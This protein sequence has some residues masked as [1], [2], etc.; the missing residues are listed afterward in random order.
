MRTLRF[1]LQK[2]FRQIFRDRAIVA[3]ILALPIVQ[4]IILPLAADYEIKNI[5]V[6]IVDHDHSTYTSRLA[7]QLSYSSY[8][9]LVGYSENHQEAM[10]LLDKDE[11]DLFLEF[12]VGFESN[13]IRENGAKVFIG[14]NAVNG[15]KGNLG[16]VY[17]NQ[18]LRGFNQDI[19]SEWLQLPRYNLQARIEIEHRHWYNGI[20]NYQIFM[21][22]GILAILLTMV[23]GFLTALNIVKEKEIGTIEQLNVTP[24]KKHHFILGKLI[25]FWILGMVVL[26][27]GL[28]VSYLVYGI[29]PL[30]SWGTLYGFSALYLVSIL[31][32]GLLVSTLANTQQQAMFVAF[33]FMLIFILLSGLF[34]LVESMP[35]WAQGIAKLTPAYYFVEVLRMIILKGA[36]FADVTNQFL[37][38]LAFGLVLNALAIWNYRKRA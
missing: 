29:V 12:P 30:G 32:F 35:I 36:T 2:E 8:F 14:V 24:I 3:L 11:A 10:S 7:N 28:G 27:V 1:L 18:V 16:A 25:P 33:F 38:V 22:P 31:G 9:N 19:R 21:V 17:A 13:L 15:V 6:A 34:T 5:N 37:I 26:T 20:M 4:L 23:G